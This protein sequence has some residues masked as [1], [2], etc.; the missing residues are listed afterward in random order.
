MLVMFR[1]LMLKSLQGFVDIG[2]MER[3]AVHLV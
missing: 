3:V 2:G 1:F